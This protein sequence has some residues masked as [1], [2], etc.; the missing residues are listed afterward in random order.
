MLFQKENIRCRLSAWV[1]LVLSLS[2]LLNVHADSL[3]DGREQT[4]KR[5]G[6]SLAQVD[7]LMQCEEELQRE[8]M[9]AVKSPAE[10]GPFQDALK[11]AIANIDATSIP[12]IP[13]GNN[14]PVSFVDQFV[15]KKG[16]EP[17]AT[18]GLEEMMKPGFMGI[19]T[20]NIVDQYSLNLFDDVIN[21]APEIIMPILQERAEK[22]PPTPA[23][24]IL[25]GFLHV[26]FEDNDIDT[27]GFDAHRHDPPQVSLS[28]ASGL[29]QMGHAKNPIY[30]LLAVQAAN[31]IEKD[32]AKLLNFYS[33]CMNETDPFI[34]RCLIDGIAGVD[35]AQATDMLK[36]LLAKTQKDGDIDNTA[37]IQKAIQWRSKVT[38][39]G[40]IQKN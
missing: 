13:N 14:L 39:S 6:I 40:T 32:K 18:K 25:Y 20:D 31:M 9:L 37:N 17:F 21:T 2:L 8:Y 23:D 34:R 35:S 22:F 10:V 38:T 30:R 27:F 29:L 7:S 11:K 16:V 24:Y 1:L 33:A 3:S 4:A 36:E 26:G 15:P 19:P 28:H 5:L 12:V